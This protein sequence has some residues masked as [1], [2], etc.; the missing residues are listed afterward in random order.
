MS[1]SFYALIFVVALAPTIL[2]GL[3]LR[4]QPWEL[5]DKVSAW[6]PFIKTM[7]IAGAIIVGLASF[8]RFLDQRQQESMKDNIERNEART[9]AFTQAIRASSAIATAT[10]LTGPEEANAVTTFWRLYWGE[11]GRFEGPQVEG[12]MVRFGRALQ[13]WQQSGQKPQG[14]EALSLEVAHSCRMEIDTYQKEIDALKN[15]YSL[16]LQTR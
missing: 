13:S 3:W 2:F 4:K 6:D 9:A 7:A 16:F 11:L 14:I 5:K 8:E 10:A 1:M 12:A 15:R